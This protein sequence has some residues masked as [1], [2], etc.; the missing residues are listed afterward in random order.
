MFGFA[1]MLAPVSRFSYYLE[2]MCN[3]Y[4]AKTVDHELFVKKKEG[5][6][7]EKLENY[8]DPD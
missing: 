1:L 5:D 3:L 7:K 2:Q 6:D 4:L 8:L